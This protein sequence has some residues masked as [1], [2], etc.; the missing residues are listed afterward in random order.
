MS[1]NSLLLKTISRK[2]T[3]RF[4][5]RNSKFL[6]A[7]C[8]DT[9]SWQLG[10]IRTEIEFLIVFINSF[11]SWSKSF[12]ATYAKRRK[13]LNEL[14]IETINMLRLDLLEKSFNKTVHMVWWVFVCAL[15][16]FI[17]DTNICYYWKGACVLFPW[18]PRNSWPWLCMQLG[19]SGPKHSWLASPTRSRWVLGCPHH[20]MRQEWSAKTKI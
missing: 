3:I 9:N 2:Q 19:H 5:G 14:D 11:F 7:Q 10:P 18:S 17:S 16:V 20:P 12:V 4:E 8:C 15:C 6:I 1:Y 13:L